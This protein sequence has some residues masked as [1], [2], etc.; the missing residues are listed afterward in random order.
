MIVVIQA[1]ATYRFGYERN[2]GFLLNYALIGFIVFCKDLVMA[3]SVSARKPL[4]AGL[5]V[6]LGILLSYSYL[7]ISQVQKKSQDTLCD[8]LKKLSVVE[9]PQADANLGIIF[10]NIGA[11]TP[12]SLYFPKNWH[13]TDFELQVGQHANLALLI[14]KSKEFGW[15]ISFRDLY[16][17]DRTLELPKMDDHTV[18][19]VENSYRVVNYPGRCYAL[20]D[21][22]PK[23]E[24]IFVIWYID[25]AS[26]VITSRKLLKHLSQYGLRYFRQQIRYQAKLSV[27]GRITN[28]VLFSENEKEFATVLEMIRA[29]S[30]DFGDKAIA[31]VPDVSLNGNSR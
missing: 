18:L 4:L 7:H 9:L 20:T 14:R 29:G 28:I 30:A 2:Y 15:R 8:F 26:M 10:C 5:Y 6:I 27:F 12:E 23:S 16:Y 3:V 31:F 13:E 19:D 11:Q 21:S 25:P 24:S 22:L 1:I 17:L